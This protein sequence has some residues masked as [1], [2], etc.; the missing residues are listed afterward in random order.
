VVN[1]SL[2]E[3]FSQGRRP[4]IVPGIEALDDESHQLISLGAQ[5]MG[6]TSF[7]PMFVVDGDLGEHRSCV[8]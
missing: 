7:H 5:P 2:I 1:M 3:R 6:R 8:E 4:T